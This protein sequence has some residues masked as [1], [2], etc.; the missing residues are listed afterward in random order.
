VK[1]DEDSCTRPSREYSSKLANF[2]GVAFVVRILAVFVTS[3]P[4]RNLIR[5][6]SGSSVGASERN[7]G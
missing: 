2:H 7:K 1:G 4:N 6:S 5:E 3:G